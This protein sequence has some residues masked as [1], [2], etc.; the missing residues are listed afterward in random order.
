MNED[1]F[2]LD[3][4][5]SNLDVLVGDSDLEEIEVYFFGVVGG[6]GRAALAF[7][8][9]VPLMPFSFGVPLVTVDSF[10]PF[11]VGVSLVPFNLMPV[12]EATMGIEPLD[13]LRG[14]LITGA[15]VDA[16]FPSVAGGVETGDPEESARSL[17]GTIG[18]VI[19]DAVAAG[20]G[21]KATS[22]SG[23]ATSGSGYQ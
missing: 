23:E 11:S 1:L 19:L 9:C 15:C 3:R 17:T 22:G 4:V 7:L 10:F 5:L 2:F 20:S 12:S 21:V 18:M 16:S 13:G 8:L 6:D 14:L